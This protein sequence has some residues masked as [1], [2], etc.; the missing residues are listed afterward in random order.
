MRLPLSVLFEANES[1]SNCGEHH[2]GNENV[3]MIKT[4]EN[5][6]GIKS[7][8]IHTH[9]HTHTFITPTIRDNIKN[10]ACSPMS[11]L[12][13]YQ[14]PLNTTR[15]IGLEFQLLFFL[16]FRLGLTTTIFSLSFSPSPFTSLTFF[17]WVFWQEKT[18]DTSRLQKMKVVVEVLKPL[19]SWSWKFGVTGARDK[20]FQRIISS[21]LFQTFSAQR[22]HRE[23]SP[24]R[25]LLCTQDEQTPWHHPDSWHKLSFTSVLSQNNRTSYFS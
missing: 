23:A 15:M 18:S 24:V 1:G 11:K 12:C 20:T 5:Y 8:V 25:L 3:K 9:T 6:T 7:N 4:V 22:V 14:S 2:L 19:F 13:L 16:F 21:G 10:T 17:C